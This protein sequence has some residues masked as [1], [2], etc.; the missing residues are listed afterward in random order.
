VTRLPAHERR[1]Q[2]LMVA[3]GLFRRRHYG[4]VSLDEVAD[5]AGVTRGLINHHFGTK[6]DLYIAVIEQIVDVEL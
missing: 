3:T 4:E 1:R 5:M 2:I 6:R